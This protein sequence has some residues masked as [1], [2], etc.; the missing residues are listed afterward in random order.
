MTCARWCSRWGTKTRNATAECWDSQHQTLTPLRSLAILSVT[1]VKI[2]PQVLCSDAPV[3][4]ISRNVLISMSAL[5]GKLN[6]IQSVTRLIFFPWWSMH[7]N[8]I[9][10]VLGA[11]LS[12]ILFPEGPPSSFFNL[13]MPNVGWLPCVCFSAY[14]WDHWT[15]Q[16]HRVKQLKFLCWAAYYNSAHCSCLKHSLMTL[17]SCWTDILSFIATSSC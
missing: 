15:C 9:S 17:N 3:Q 10:S 5:F 2:S 8:Q 11:L 14:H 12:P 1:S 16:H 13:L 7:V 6:N 4:I